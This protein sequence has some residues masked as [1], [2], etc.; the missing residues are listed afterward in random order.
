MGFS[1]GGRRL[2]SRKVVV[3]AWFF[4]EFGRH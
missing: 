3:A 1:I 2:T 4:K